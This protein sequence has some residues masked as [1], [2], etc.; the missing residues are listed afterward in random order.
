[1][2]KIDLEKIAGAVR[3]AIPG[4][5]TVWQADD[6]RH[7]TLY[8]ST[9]SWTKVVCLALDMPEMDTTELVQNILDALEN[10]E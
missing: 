10:M 7:P 4:S 6:P 9:R 3:D 2:A 8:I 1:M 5:K